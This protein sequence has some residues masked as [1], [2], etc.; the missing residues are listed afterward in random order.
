MTTTECIRDAAA[1]IAHALGAVQGLGL[2]VPPTD[3]L[4]SYT[5]HGCVVRVED[6]SAAHREAV[7]GKFREAFVAAG[8]EAAERYA[9]GLSMR[10][11]SGV[12]RL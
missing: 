5:G 8:W 10:H 12:T 1:P 2:N 11:P 9:G 3:V 6:R 4:I 7:H